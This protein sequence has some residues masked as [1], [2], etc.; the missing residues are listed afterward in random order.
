MELELEL[1]LKSIPIP[2][3][4]PNLNQTD[5][6]TTFIYTNATKFYQLSTEKDIDLWDISLQWSNNGVESV[7]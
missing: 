7:N 5:S 6:S 3:L 4:T 1:E 2:E